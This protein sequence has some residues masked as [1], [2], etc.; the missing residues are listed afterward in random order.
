MQ[1]DLMEPITWEGTVPFEVKAYLPHP[2]G[3]QISLWT[4]PKHVKMVPFLRVLLLM[5]NALTGFDR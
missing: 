4:R 3:L 5:T 2:E 1:L